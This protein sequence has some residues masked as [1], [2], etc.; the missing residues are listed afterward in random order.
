M[1]TR[2]SANL[3]PVQL[4]IFVYAV[5]LRKRLPET[6]RG[7]AIGAGILIVSLTFCTLEQ[8]RSDAGAGCVEPRFR[9]VF[10]RRQRPLFYATLPCRIPAHAIPRRLFHSDFHCLCGFRRRCWRL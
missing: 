1:S 6:A 8:P 9:Q 3:A 2:K 5:L 7:H 4:L 10:A